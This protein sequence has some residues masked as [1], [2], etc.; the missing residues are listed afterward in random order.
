MALCLWDKV[1]AA[2]PPR[3]R[4]VWCLPQSSCRVPRGCVLQA[5]CAH[6]ART[7]RHHHGEGPRRCPRVLPARAV[8][9]VR[10]VCL[11]S[12]GAALSWGTCRHRCPGDDPFGGQ[13]L[14]RCLPVRSASASMPLRRALTGVSLPSYCMPTGLASSVSLSNTDLE[15]QESSTDSHSARSKVHR[16]CNAAGWDPAM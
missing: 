13:A 11:G 5:R 7:R 14:E 1:A 15:E 8:D 9:G 3:A 16:L 10:P 2:A 6:G 4:P 12:T